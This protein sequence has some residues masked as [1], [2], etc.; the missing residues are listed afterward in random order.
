MRTALFI[1]AFL[2]S[3][4]SFGH[5]YYFA[6]AEVEYNEMNG[7]IEATLRVSTHDLEKVLREKNLIKND[8]SSIS[9][10][11]ATL[12]LLEKEIETHFSISFSGKN[13][14]FQLEGFETLKTGLVEFYL[15]SDIQENLEKMEIKFDLL[16][17]EFP[18]QQN[19]MTFMHR[20]SKTTLVF[21]QNKRTQY[22]D[23]N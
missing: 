6:F 20:M 21:M 17:E 11:T 7:K 23:L 14:D 16:M 3:T 2:L 18:E 15:S 19:K 9:Q 22:I 10:D 1:F 12:S 13:L 4:V 8:L 5:E